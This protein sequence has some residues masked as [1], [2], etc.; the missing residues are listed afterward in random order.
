MKKII[1]DK[2]VKYRGNDIFWCVSCDTPSMQCKK[3]AEFSCT[4]TGC[5]YCKDVTETF[6]I[7]NHVYREDKLNKVGE[8]EKI[9]LE[10]IFN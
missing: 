1:N 4:G 10:E 7:V 2:N 9:L 8:K 3:C 5:E 6:L